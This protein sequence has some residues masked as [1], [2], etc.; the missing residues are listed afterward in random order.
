MTKSNLSLLSLLVLAQ[1][2]AFGNAQI[3]GPGTL[4]QRVPEIINVFRWVL[5][6]EGEKNFTAIVGDTMIFRWQ[7]SQHNVF[8]HPSGTCELEDAIFVGANPGTS[9]TF[10]EVDGSDEGTDMFFACDI[11][12][13]AH[14][15][16]GQSLTVKV[17]SAP[18]PSNATMAPTMDGTPSGTV[19]GTMGGSD[20]L[21]GNNV[22]NTS[23]TPDAGGPTSATE[24]PVNVTETPVVSESEAE[25]PVVESNVTDFTDADDVEEPAPVVEN[26]PTT[27]AMGSETDSAMAGS[28]GAMNSVT[29]VIGIVGACV[30][31]ALALV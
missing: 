13:G 7:N 18:D 23:A 30:S 6:Y 29:S 28:G 8:I 17:F 4:I 21:G 2:S 15:L 31:L 14:C 25:A 9:Y 12:N 10:S 5:P 16:A 20:F 1:L 11:N 22:N 19:S 3:L 24:V 26:P 27:D